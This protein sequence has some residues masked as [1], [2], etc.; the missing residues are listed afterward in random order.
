VVGVTV[1]ASSVTQ[2]F[3]MALDAVVLIAAGSAGVVSEDE[4]LR[5]AAQDFAA[6]L[7]LIP[8]DFMVAVVDSIVV[9][10]DSMVVVVD[11]TVAADFTGVADTDNRVSWQTPRRV[12]NL[13]NEPGPAANAAG[14]PFYETDALRPQLE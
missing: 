1:A 4:V 6:A 14:L 3:A 5:G 13:Q 2:D 12:A 11:S 9:V 10:V 8:A 7:T